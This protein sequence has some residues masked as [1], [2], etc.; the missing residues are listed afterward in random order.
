MRRPWR[1]A[2]VVLF[3]LTVVAGSFLGDR[4]LALSD[5]SREGLRQYTELVEA[6][7]QN[8][9][10]EVTYKDVVYSSIHGMLRQLDP[11][12]SFLPPEAYQRMRD[13][14]QSSFYGLGI[15]VG[16]RDG[17]LTVIA[18]LEGTP[19]SRMGIR[20]G[21]VITTIEGE[22]TSEM[23]LDD[24]VQKLKGPKDTEVNITIGRRGVSEPLEM[25]IKR[26]EIPLNTVRYV[27]M[28]APGTGYF[29]ITEFSRSTGKEVAQAIAALRAQGM[30]RLLLDLRNNGGGLLDQAIAVADQF[31]P[32]GTL[33][34]ETKGRIRDSFQKFRA[35]G[36][37]R[38]LDLPLVVLVN[39]GSASAAEILAGAIQDHDVGVIV[40]T[41]TWGKG[42]VQTV[43]GLPYDGALALTTAS[44]YTP[45]GR[46]IQRDYTS[47]YDY[48][49]HGD[50]LLEDGE[51]AAGRGIELPAGDEPVYYTDLGR[52]VYGGGGITPDVLIHPQESPELL[53][54]LEARNAFFLFGVEYTAGKAALTADWQPGPDV[55]PQ[56]EAWVA[57]E[58]MVDSP[59]EIDA[60]LQDADTRAQVLARI[61]AEALNATLGN[62]A[63]YRALAEQ[64]SQIREALR[65]FDKASEL[66]AMRKGGRD[67]QRV[68]EGAARR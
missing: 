8:Y 55:L 26:A 58:G 59:G 40:G 27:M 23:L 32:E 53:Q 50:G 64:D 37:H 63:R 42:L 38:P 6:A 1:L 13:R 44:Y 21:D 34:V 49:A 18:P 60:A 36:D 20:A 39:S 19:A 62:D 48:Y 3:A 9:G 22:P 51:E 24:A 10:G 11:H 14:Q 15:L 33:I 31:V 12:T 43:Y 4:L 35:E 52:K 56:F 2:A 17:Q 16:L 65:M 41:P 29:R 68:A 25:T 5:T 66:L 30:E 54:F 45:S 46:L 67:D 47:F 7:R 28:I 57:R 61:R